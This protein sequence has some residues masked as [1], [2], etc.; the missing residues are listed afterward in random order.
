MTPLGAAEIAALP[1][2]QCV[3]LAIVRPGGH[4]F[5]G[6]RLDTSGAWQMPQGGIDA[7]ESP[8]IAALRELQEETGLTEE[9]VSIVGESEGWIRYDLPSDLIGKAFK[10]RFRGQEQK[11]FLMRFDGPDT[12]ISIDTE[13]P[14]FGRWQWMTPEDLL[15]SIVPFKRETYAAVFA[16]FGDR[17]QET[18]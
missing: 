13:H 4:V 18:L 8:R 7:G 5:A 10:G 2:R 16:E 15:A 14:E 6:E 11:W 12:Q 9:V 17:I 3:G 1:Y